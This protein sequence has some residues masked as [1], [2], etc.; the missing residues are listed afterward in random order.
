MIASDRL[1]APLAWADRR[2]AGITNALTGPAYW[3]LL[4]GWVV[5]LFA[6]RIA[7]FPAG[8]QDDAEQLLYMQT[9][10]GGYHPAQP[11]VYTW[12]LWLGHQILAP[13]TGSAL[14]SLLLVKGAL[15]LATFIFMTLA[16]GEMLPE[17]D[18]RGYRAT[19]RLA[20]LSLWS[21]FYVGYEVVYSYS[22]TVT[23]MTAIAAT[24]WTLA[25]LHRAGTAGN[26]LM[27]GAAVGFGM[28]SKYGYA[29]FVGTL[30]L[31]ALSV[32]GFRARLL[33]WRVLLAMGITGMLLLPHAVWILT[34]RQDLIAAFRGRLIGH[35]DVSYLSK[36]AKG[37]FKI[38]VGLLIFFAPLWIFAPAHLTRAIWPW[39]PA[40]QAGLEWRQVLLRF[41]VLVLLTLAGGV[42]AFGI[43]DVRTHYMFIFLGLPLYLLLRAKAVQTPPNRYARWGAAMAI[44]AGVWI[45]VALGRAWLEPAHFKRAYMHM[46][47]GAIAAKLRHAGFRGGTIIAHFHRTQLAGNLA[48][49]FP[50]SR[51]ISTKYPFYRLPE[52]RVVAGCLLVWEAA[53]GRALPG[54][55]RHLA[56]RYGIKDLPKQAPAAANALVPGGGG[57]VFRLYY[58]LRPSGAACGG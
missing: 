49:E 24:L 39:S 18:L 42:L 21:V 46:P 41:G 26:Y 38:G 31:A 40:G 58:V 48:V 33:H 12:L 55:L 28:L 10:A 27:F 54:S 44:M 34:E 11:P 32:S 7:L 8:S 6:I 13:L 3:P 16:A 36:V 14:V 20:A 35:D 1:T 2:W 9:L 19:A 4:V 52:R 37:F 29:L 45:A 57:R 23:Y 5:V 22:N 51:V 56:G 50:A 43:A 15:Y 30:L 53:K 47:Y 25:R 17:R